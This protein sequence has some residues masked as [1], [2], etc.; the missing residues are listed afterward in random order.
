MSFTIILVFSYNS[1]IF[2]WNLFFSLPPQYPLH[3]SVITLYVFF[4]PLFSPLSSLTFV[5][6]TYPLSLLISLSFTPVPP[7]IRSTGAS[8][9]SVV[10]HKPISLQCVPNGTPLP[11]ITW[12]KDGRPV[13]TAQE[14]LKV[15]DMTLPPHL[16]ISDTFVLAPPFVQVY[17]YYKS[18]LQ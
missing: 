16:A 17:Y 6:S 12:L 4:L 9:R 14:H 8:E 18:Q 1:G 5:S 7:S 10:L 15:Q 2:L 3:L 11:S 13:D